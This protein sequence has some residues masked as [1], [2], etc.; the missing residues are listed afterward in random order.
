M[1][2]LPIGESGSPSAS[3][4]RYRKKHQTDIRILIAITSAGGIIV[5]G[6]QGKIDINNTFEE[7][8]RLL[9]ETGLPAVRKTLFGNNPNR[10]FF[11]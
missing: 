4:R 10:K 1:L 3:L 5:I 2:Y 11:D 7:R 8:L 6:G 9:Q